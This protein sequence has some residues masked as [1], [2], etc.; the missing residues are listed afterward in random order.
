MSAEARKLRVAFATLGCKV[1]QYD[2]ATMETALREGCEMVPFGAGADVYVVNSCSVTDR[3]DAESRQL[4]RRA[5]RL[6]PHGRVILT[7][8][9]AQ[10]SPQRAALPEV[11]Y[12]IGVGRLRDILRAVHDQ[13][14]A[15][16]GRVLVDNLRKAEHVTTLGA[17]VFDGQTRA[18]LKVQEGCDLFCTFCIVPFARGR[19]RSVAPRRVLDELERLAARGYREVVLTGI[20]L[21]GYGKDLQPALTLADLI[22]MIAAVS[23]LPRIRLSSIDPPEVTPRLLQLLAQSPV[24]CPHLHMPVQAAADGVLRRMRRLYD[25]AMV[26]D[27][28]AEVVRTL[29]DAAL[30]T[31]VIAGFPGESA[32]E[33]DASLELLRAAPF[34]YFHV[35]PYSRRRGTTAAKASDH[36]AAATIKARAQTLRAL[37]AAKRW[38]F[39]RRFIGT[40]LGV[41]LETTR[42]RDSGHMVGYSRNYLRV[43][44]DAPDALA[45]T[46]VRVRAVMQQR[47]R[48]VGVVTEAVEPQMNADDHGSVAGRRSLNG[49]GEEI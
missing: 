38:A 22:E 26:R 37:G 31:D 30:G 17:E 12:V 7:G 28:A 40:E 15:A 23:P 2:T 21:G 14:P 4:A 39:A 8:C 10:T 6:N 32:A 44:V 25:A 5:R 3:A 47:D 49:P 24:L 29:P 48:L 42:D 11:D 34:T 45:N 35:F 9:F 20:H 46:E 27:V 36:L 13:I 18:F 16:D 41:L 33:F 1:N 43:V 19:S